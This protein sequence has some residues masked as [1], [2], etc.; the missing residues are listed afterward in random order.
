LVAQ[1]LGGLGRPSPPEGEVEQVFP[2]AGFRRRL[3]FDPD[4]GDQIA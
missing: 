1:A 4:H 2:G 3:G